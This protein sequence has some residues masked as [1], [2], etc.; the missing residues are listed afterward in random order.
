LRCEK[1][2][3]EVRIFILFEELPQSARKTLD[4]LDRICMPPSIIALFLFLFA[5]GLTLVGL[6]VK[7]IANSVTARRHGRRLS[8]FDLILA[9]VILL[10]GAVVAAACL[11]VITPTWDRL[12]YAILLGSSCIASAVIAIRLSR[13]AKRPDAPGISL[14]PA[15]APEVSIQAGVAHSESQQAWPHPGVAAGLEA[16][17]VKRTRSAK[18]HISLA[19][20][21]IVPAALFVLYKHGP[22][23][24]GLAALFS[25]AF[26]AECLP[27]LGGVSEVEYRGLPGSRDAFGKHRCVYC[28]KR[29]VYKRGAY[30]SNSTWH[31]CTGC[32]KHLFVD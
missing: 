7:T 30:A 22:I 9:P 14:S 10:L 27:P 19:L 2:G 3:A 32:R 12:P 20:I 21:I 31:E 11:D 13:T 4:F 25:L 5:A 1:H 8:A 26:V 6:G 15:T 18:K 23:A 28:G 16:I 29:G 24:A 17:R